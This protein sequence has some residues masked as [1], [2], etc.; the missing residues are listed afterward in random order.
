MTSI[1]TIGRSARRYA[2]AM[3]A[4]VY[5]FNFIDRQVLAILL[6]SIKA[7]FSVDDWVLG[8]LAGPAF[9]LF[10]VT[11]GIP[12]AVLG[13]RWNRRNLIAISLA[14]WSA[15]TA[16]SGA[17]SSIVQLS[18]ARIGVGVGEAGFSPPAHS[19]IADMY[20][21]ERRSLAM[22]VFTLGISLGIMIAYLGGG[23]MA[24]NIGWRQA[25][26]VVGVPGLALAALFRATVAEPPRGMSEGRADN[27]ERFSVLEVARY[28]MARKS[29]VHM[30]LGAGLASFTAYAVLSF[31]PSFLER[32]HGMDLQ[33]I[34]ALVG[35]IIGVSTGI[36][37][38]GGGW[39]ADHVGATS[40]RYSLW[41]MSAA[42]M[43][44]WV[45]VFPLY[46]LTD[47][48]VVLAVFFVPSLLNNLYLGTTFA[49][50]QGLVGLRMRSVASALL[51]FVI[52]VLGLGF[53][54][55]AAGWLSDLLA[56]TAGNESLRYSLLIIGAVTGPWIAW[57]FYVAGRYIEGDLARVGEA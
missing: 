49:Q 53:G 26:F 48:F 11:L 16:L 13:D 18:L 44:G 42:M 23:W 1:V 25:F 9:A 24:Q 4:T 19:M 45:F 40:R 28:L 52:N 22:G 3:I 30:S 17:A 37:F 46:L 8:F 31:F 51:L 15:M 50:T 12:I 34:G 41:I 2:L 32:S 5:V 10:Y 36:G 38:V 39:I 6:P 55:L 29:F 47:P 27:N 33:Q 35:I 43:L 21:P 7:E 54:P 56:A 14:I 57:H 20:P